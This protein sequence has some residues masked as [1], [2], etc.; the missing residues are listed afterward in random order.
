MRS[1]DSSYDTAASATPDRDTCHICGEHAGEDAADPRGRGAICESC[2]HMIH[3]GGTMKRATQF[4]HR[5]AGSHIYHADK[6][7]Y[8]WHGRALCGADIGRAFMYRSGDP[9]SWKG[10]E[11]EEITHF[12]RKY[13]AARACGHCVKRAAK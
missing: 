2:W 10:A 4:W 7:D 3:T 12:P 1:I 6:P 5:N 13:G 8:S 11:C 9:A